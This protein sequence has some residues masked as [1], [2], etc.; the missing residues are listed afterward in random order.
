ML[1]RCKCPGCGDLKEYV[2]EGI[3][4]E[5]ND[6]VIDVGSGTGVLSFVA[7]RLGA[8]AVYGT[9]VNGAAIELARLP[10][11]LPKRPRRP[12]ALARQIL[13][14]AAIVIAGPRTGQSNREALAEIVDRTSGHWHGSPERGDSL[15]I[16]WSKR[17]PYMPRNGGSDR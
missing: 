12:R 7:A 14:G 13:V 4:I 17:R 9:E 6:T 5:R 11:N 15:A 2:A 8:G 1:L 16:T 10:I 3:R